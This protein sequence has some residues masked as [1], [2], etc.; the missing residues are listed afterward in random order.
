[1]F[2]CDIGASPLKSQ[3]FVIWCTKFALK[4]RMTC[5]AH[6]GGMSLAKCKISTKNNLCILQKQIEKKKSVERLW[7]NVRFQ[8]K[9]TIYVFCKNK[10]KKISR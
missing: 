9:K 8:Q 2:L 6:G 4:G 5:L 1:M 10:L 7:L 3:H